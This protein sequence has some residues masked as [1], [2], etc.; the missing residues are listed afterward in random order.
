MAVARPEGPRGEQALELQVVTMRPRQKI[1]N[2]GASA[3]WSLDPIG[4]TWTRE[5]RERIADLLFDQRKGIGLSVFRFNIGA[6]SAWTDELWDPWRGAECFRRG[7][8]APNDWSRQAGQQWFLKAAWKRG[9]RQLLAC[10]YSPPVWLTRNG[11]A[12][13]DKGARESN[14]RPGAEPEFARFLADVLDHFRKQGTPF[15]WISPV[16]EPQW[17]WEGG[18]EGCSYNH[19]ELKRL[20]RALHDELTRRRIPC[21]IDALEAGDIRFLLDDDLYR[22]WSGATDPSAAYRHGMELRGGKYREAIRELLGDPETAAILGSHISAHSYW[23]DGDDRH[24]RLLRETLRENLE[25]VKPRPTYWQTEYCVMEHGRDLGMPTALRV[26]AVIHHDLVH[27][28]AS[29]WHWWLAVS[30]NDYKD[31]L[32]YTDF[33]R[34]GEQNILPSKTL[35]ALGNF[36]RF[37]RPGSRRV[38]MLYPHAEGPLLASAY[39]APKNDRLVVICINRS[40]SGRRVR[41]LTD[42]QVT[43]WEAWLTSATCDLQRAELGDAASECMLPPQ[44]VVTLV[45]TLRR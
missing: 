36:S 20:L 41:L 6:G 13:A 2:F 24:L 18:Q 22:R 21:R 33:R 26:A 15:G 40:E 3:A 10:V 7:P 9:V 5:N 25:R 23:T 16:N 4:S 19:E 11:H 1:D 32:I 38:E 45:G 31:G 30:P 37:L 35:W 8:D 17:A 14:L 39:I 27:A 12:H 28:E 34:T 42:R 29:A 44:S 43:R